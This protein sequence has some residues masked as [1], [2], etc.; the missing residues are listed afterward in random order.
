M[1]LHPEIAK[2]LD[3]VLK[4]GTHRISNHF[5]DRREERNPLQVCHG[6]EIHRSQ[7]WFVTQFHNST[8]HSRLDVNVDNVVLP[9]RGNRFRQKHEA[10][11]FHF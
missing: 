8:D 2:I 7:Y 9:V 11:D 3:P 1:I 6:N 10:F 4:A 5:T